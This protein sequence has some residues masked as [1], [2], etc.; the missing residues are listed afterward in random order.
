MKKDVDK[1]TVQ[2]FQAIK[3]EFNKR[4]YNAVHSPNRQKIKLYDIVT[5]CSLFVERREMSALLKQNTGFLEGAESRGDIRAVQSY[6]D[7]IQ[8]CNRRLD[9]ITAR[10]DKLNF[11]IE[12][13]EICGANSI[14]KIADGYKCGRE[15]IARLYYELCKMT[16]EPQPE[17][18]AFVEG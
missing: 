4:F 9:T 3:K 5:Y 1:T 6:K 10:M 7:N 18:R 15:S 2:L 8:Y 16:G 12:F 14:I 17:V 11:N 13:D